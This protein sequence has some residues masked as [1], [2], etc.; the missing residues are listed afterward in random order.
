MS[1][2]K[3]ISGFLIIIIILIAVYGASVVYSV[4][5]ISY[6]TSDISI[7][8]S[9]TLTGFPP[10][11]EGYLSISTVFKLEN[12][13]FYSIKGLKIDIKITSNNWEVSSLLNGIEV[14]SGSNSIGTIAAGET[15]NGNINVDVTNFIPNFAIE[16]CT[17]LV[18]V[19][20][21]LTYQPVIDIPL[22]FTI[23]QTEQYNA[24]F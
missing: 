20:I 16:N 10:D 11:Y 7:N 5:N 6:Q 18:E 4:I 8:P 23:V 22:S 14:A 24:P 17:L 2:K 1:K 19:T 13:G 15:W 12:N 3:S 21:S 9:I